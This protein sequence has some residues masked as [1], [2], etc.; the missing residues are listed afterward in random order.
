[1]ET[2][3]SIRRWMFDFDY[4]TL[5][6]SDRVLETKPVE[7]DRPIDL[8]PMG[9]KSTIKGNYTFNE[10]FEHIFINGLGVRGNKLENK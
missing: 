8:S 1:M 3:R 5:N 2:I 6:V 7:L 10:V 9:V 4:L